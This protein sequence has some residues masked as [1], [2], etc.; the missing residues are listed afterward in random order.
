MVI[1][2]IFS[3]SG[4][5][6]DF[7]R[8]CAPTGARE[9]ASECNLVIPCGER[10]SLGQGQSFLD[11]GGPL[12]LVPS[13]EPKVFFYSRPKFQRDRQMDRIKSPQ[14]VFLEKVAGCLKG[15]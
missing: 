8:T 4:I 10:S 9:A 6:R 3:S 15:G 2:T 11:G 13:D 1:Q 12:I 5:R 14:L 7:E